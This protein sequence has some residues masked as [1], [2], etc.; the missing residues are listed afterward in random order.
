[1]NPP[2]LVAGPWPFES[3]FMFRGFPQ[4]HEALVLPLIAGQELREQLV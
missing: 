3:F 4:G 1:L 2:K